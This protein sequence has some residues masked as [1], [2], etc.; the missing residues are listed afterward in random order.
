MWGQGCK[1]KRIGRGQRFRGRRV[2]SADL[3]CENK[4][5]K[6]FRQRETPRVGS[7]CWETEGEDGHSRP[8]GESQEVVQP[9]RPPDTNCTRGLASRRCGPCTWSSSLSGTAERWGRGAPQTWSLL[10]HAS[11]R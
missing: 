11:S 6:W 1:F 7:P 2:R 8:Q 10:P 4:S 5:P 3:R 9:G